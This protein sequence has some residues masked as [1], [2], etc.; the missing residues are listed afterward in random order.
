MKT[1]YRLLLALLTMTA[2]P[3]FAQS[4]PA[5]GGL[6]ENGPYDVVLNWF[7][8]GMLWDQPVAAVAVEDQNRIFIGNADQHVTRP[9]SL[10]IDADGVTLKERSKTS[11]KPE[12]EKTHLHQIMV[13]NGDGKVTDDWK[14]W[15][16]L[17][18]T[19]H[20]LHISPYDSA[21]AL[22][23]VDRDGQQIL[24]F[25]NDGK[26]L[27]MK[28]GEKGVAGTDQGHFNRPASLTFMPDGSFYV[29]DGYVN[30]RIVKFD[31][32]GKYLLEWG[33]KGSGP[34]EFNLVH[35]VAVDAQ[36]RVYVADRSNNRIQIFDESGKF[37]DQ[38]PN[39]RQ[40]SKVMVTEDQAVWVSSAAYSRMA[41]FDTNGKLQTYWG[42]FGDAPGS[43]DNLHAF[44]VDEA[45]NYYIADTWN[46][47]VQ[48][49]VPR[50]DADKSRLI[51]KEF[52]FK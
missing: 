2:S 20:A 3:V 48:K 15:D 50:A 22:W 35:S 34:G 14:Q 28:L 49:Y 32:N 46:N 44:A 9:N 51:A 30:T 16:E 12:A 39:I 43:A 5:K 27:L 10:V 19:S 24:K 29:A 11:T 40:P 6:D 36:K 7:K 1:R 18:V 37:L 33:K 26:K 21:K 4:A 31:K 47:R 41:K 38:W 8:P 23:V 52:K 25:S 45:G 42:T 13:L 17:I